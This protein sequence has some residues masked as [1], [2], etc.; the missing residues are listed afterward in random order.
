MAPSRFDCA[1]NILFRVIKETKAAQFG[2]FTLSSGKTSSFYFDGRKVTL[3]AE[4]LYAL[5]RAFFS[6][7][8]YTI[9]DTVGGPAIG[10]IPIISA[11][12]SD[13]Q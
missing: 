13:A 6:L 1:K 5:G 7:Y 3:H 4:G 12:L 2:D 9:F 8:G 10:A 11:V